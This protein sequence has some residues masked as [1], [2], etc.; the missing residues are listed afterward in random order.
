MLL[1]KA[2]QHGAMQLKT[3]GRHFSA[4]SNVQEYIEDMSTFIESWC[5]DREIQLV[6]K[7]KGFEAGRATNAANLNCRRTSAYNCEVSCL[8]CPPPLVQA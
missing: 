8:Q 2:C 6:R 5:K 4:L 3:D 7:A 1:K